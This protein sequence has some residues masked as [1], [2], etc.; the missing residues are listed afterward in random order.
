VR[1][2]RLAAVA[3]VL[4]LAGLLGWHLTHQ[5]T[6]TAKAVAHGKVVP[7]PR[8]DLS[9]LEGKGRVTLAS[10]RGKA[11]VVNF[12]ASDCGPCKKEMPQLERASRRWATKNV[13]VVGIDALD[14]RGAARKF[15]H[16]H[17]ITYPIGFDQVGDAVVPYGVSYTPTTFFVDRHG[18]IVKRVLGP[19]TDAVLDAHIRRALAS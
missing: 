18:R 5:D 12:W 6:A 19:M 14:F 17:G 7:A 4:V 2:A 8:F 16:S 9:R 13:A 11:V 10:F 1:L 15:V 3:S